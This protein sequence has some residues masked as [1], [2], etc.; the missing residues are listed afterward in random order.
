MDS[1][2]SGVKYLFQEVIGKGNSEIAI[3]SGL[4]L[5]YLC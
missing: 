4:M 2:P 1:M 5:E 3:L